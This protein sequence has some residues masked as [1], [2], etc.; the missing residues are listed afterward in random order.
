MRLKPAVIGTVVTFLASSLLLPLFLPD[1]MAYRWQL[2]LV[3]ALGVAVLGLTAWLRRP[4]GP[5]PSSDLVRGDKETGVHW[6]SRQLADMVAKNWSL[7]AGQ[8]RLESPERAMAIPWTF[9]RN[10]LGLQRLDANASEWAADLAVAVRS[11]APGY[12]GEKPYPAGRGVVLEGADQSGKSSAAALL[13]L[14]LLKGYERDQD[15]RLVPVPFDLAS[16]DHDLDLQTWLARQLSARYGWLQNEEFGPSAAADLIDGG[17]V[18]PILDGFED[19]PDAPDDPESDDRGSEL[20]SGDGHDRY[21]VATLRELISSAL[22]G[23]VLTSQTETFE[24]VALALGSLSAV[25]VIRIE[26]GSA[27][28]AR[29]VIS[30]A[31]RDQPETRW[32]PILAEI[33]AHPE[34]ALGSAL[35]S[36]LMTSLVLDVY[37]PGGVDPGRLLQLPDRDSVEAHLL[38]KLVGRAFEPKASD[39]TRR[40][41]W[42]S[43]DARRWLG[44]IADS[45]GTN[46]EIRWWRLYAPGNRAPHLIAGAFTFLVV[47]SS[48]G[49]AVA[50]LFNGFL[51]GIVGGLLAIVVGWFAGRNDPPSPSELQMTVRDHVRS[52][53]KSGI[54]IAL[55]V[56]VV[57]TWV[58]DLAFGLTFGAVFGL[59]VGSLYALTQSDQ[60]PRPITPGYL[61]QRDLYLGATYGLAYGAPAIVV[62]WFLSD[63]ILFSVVLGLACAAAGACLYGPIWAFALKGSRV[64]VVPFG[65][66][67]IATLWFAPQGKLPWNV[68]AFLSAARDGDVLRNVGGVYKFRHQRLQ[69]ALS[70]EGGS[71]VRSQSAAVA[72]APVEVPSP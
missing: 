2:L 18:L 44:H 68:M 20:N 21:R 35:S 51:G 17:Y 28:E 42:R 72:V 23:W 52:A 70:S 27:A 1:L 15:R 29:Q 41:R 37:A 7:E 10:P 3:S 69:A 40:R 34:G 45:V 8:R 67:A 25:T 6:A 22:P 57:G 39:R 59:V 12:A 19:I 56:L 47:L 16:G 13:T 43:R 53:L 54:P 24:R 46:G 33:D 48:V 38:D 50:A 64:S 58:R 55:I 30:N 32:A 60:V 14:R 36:R 4:H 49:M 31:T 61:L 11:V 65:H 26:P 5:R 62:G 71:P 9:V 63:N 66:L